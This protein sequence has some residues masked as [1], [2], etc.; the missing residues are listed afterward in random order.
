MIHRRRRNWSGPFLLLL[1]Q[2][3]VLLLL[4]R[5]PQQA[6][7]VTATNN[8]IN[9]DNALLFPGKGGNVVSPSSTHKKTARNFPS[10]HRFKP[11]RSSPPLD[12]FHVINLDHDKERWESVVSELT[13]KGGVPIRKIKRI[14][15][16]YGK[17]LTSDD[18]CTNTTFVARHFST[19]GTIGC[20]MSH[21]NCWEQTAKGSYPYQ[22][23]LEDDVLVTEKFPEKV[24][25]ILQEINENCPE[26]RNGNWD[27]IFLGALGLDASIL[28]K[29]T[30]S[31]ELPHSCPGDCVSLDVS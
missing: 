27:V 1:V 6:I 24:N 30:A 18:L 9:T 26:T 17:N 28:I 10:H 16:I 3:L 14:H 22:L 21:R 20:Y 2:Q 5:L 31:I 23:F 11:K 4:F 8:N 29:N 25:E 7:L 19:R 15:A 13:S 12:Y